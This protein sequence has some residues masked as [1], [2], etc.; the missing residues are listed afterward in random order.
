MFANPFAFLGPLE[1]AEEL[2]ATGLGGDAR[3]ES[4]GVGRSYDEVL[5]PGIACKSGSAAGSTFSTGSNFGECL[6]A[7]C[8]CRNHFF[9]ISIGCPTCSPQNSSMASLGFGS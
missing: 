1:V 5:V 3:I 2:S 6:R 8:L 9:I 7:A 4:G